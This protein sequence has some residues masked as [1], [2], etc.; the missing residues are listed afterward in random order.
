[1]VKNYDETFST[2]TYVTVPLDEP[3][4]IPAEGLYVGTTPRH[5]P[6]FFGRQ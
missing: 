2:N 3:V 6:F 5:S 1:M 4:T